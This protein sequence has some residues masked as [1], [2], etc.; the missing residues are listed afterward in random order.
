MNIVPISSYIT[1]VGTPDAP[2]TI[3]P[4]GQPS[5]LDVF[6]QVFDDAVTTTN[7]QAADRIRLMLGE[8]DDL[9]QIQLNM[10][11]AELAVELLV[12]VRNSVLESYNEIIR[13]QI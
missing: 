5:F 10:Q 12:N 1:A 6:K 3:R 4:A 9:E 13:M 7:T 8:A 2:Q 11:K